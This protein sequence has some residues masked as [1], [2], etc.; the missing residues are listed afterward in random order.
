MS[1]R[2]L[3]TL[4]VL[5]SLPV[6]VFLVALVGWLLVVAVAVAFSGSSGSSMPKAPAGSATVLGFVAGAIAA[7]WAAALLL[8][9]SPVHRIP[10]LPVALLAFLGG[11]LTALFPPLARPLLALGTNA[12]SLIAALFAYKP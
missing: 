5:G 9:V 7:G 10:F 12:L 8:A 6:I 2:L 4:A 3:R 1:P 11:T